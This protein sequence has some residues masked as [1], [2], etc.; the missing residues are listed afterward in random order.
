MSS[1]RIIVFIDGANLY[2][3]TKTLGYELDYVKLRDFF[4]N[5]EQDLVRL[6]YYTAIFDREEEYS[7][8]VKLV[9]FLTYNGFNLVTKPALEYTNSNGVRKVKGNMD[10]ELTTDALLMADHVGHVHIFSGDGDF[11]YLV[12]AL[13]N[14]GCVV[15]VWS[16]HRTKPS[17]IAD[18]LRRKADHFYDLADY[19]EVLART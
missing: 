2:A 8:V 10:V 4:R 12:N 3:T 9:D 11:T 5:G 7:A 6:N 13:Q 18:T 19:R 1:E 17:M 15:S 16:T 14:K